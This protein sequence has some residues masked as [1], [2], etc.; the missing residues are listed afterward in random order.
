[1]VKDLGLHTMTSSISLVGWQMEKYFLMGDIVVNVYVQI[2]Y[3]VYF[4]NIHQELTCYRLVLWLLRF[5]KASMWPQDWEQITFKAQIHSRWN[6]NMEDSCLS[7][8]RILWSGVLGMEFKMFQNW[9]M[10]SNIQSLHLMI[11]F[12]SSRYLQWRTLRTV[13]F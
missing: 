4:D 13:M 8:G 1:M 5:F 2:F 6:L 11:F 12:M 7:N 9:F 10:P 3:R